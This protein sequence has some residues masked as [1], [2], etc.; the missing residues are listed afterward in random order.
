MR[1]SNPVRSKPTT[2]NRAANTAATASPPFHL[3][4]TRKDLSSSIRAAKYPITPH[5]RMAVM[6]MISPPPV[7]MVVTMP[8]ASPAQKAT[9]YWNTGRMAL[10]DTTSPA[11]S[12]RRAR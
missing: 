9:P 7:N 3:P 10:T 2:Q 8:K 4:N 6:S 11:L 1:V 5:T 12:S